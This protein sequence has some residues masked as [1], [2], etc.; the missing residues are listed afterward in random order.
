MP[1]DSIVRR[2][3]SNAGFADFRLQESRNGYPSRSGRDD[4][5]KQATD[6]MIEKIR[7]LKAIYERHLVPLGAVALQ[8][9]LAHAAVV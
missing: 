2:V 3:P 7:K 1:A 6:A 9:P 8:F 5:Y 4:G